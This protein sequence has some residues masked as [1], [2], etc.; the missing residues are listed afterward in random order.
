MPAHVRF[1]PLTPG[2]RLGPYEIAAA[3][4]AGRMREVYKASDRKVDRDVA[5]EVLPESADEC[6]ARFEREARTPAQL[7]HPNTAHFYRFEASDGVHALV[8]E[9]VEGLPLLR[10]L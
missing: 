3:V 4:G 7:N 5:I 8:M 2:T 10:C 1:M 6:I 9:L